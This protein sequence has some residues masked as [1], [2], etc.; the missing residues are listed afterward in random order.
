LLRGQAFAPVATP[1]FDRAPGVTHDLVWLSMSSATDGAIVRYTTNG[2]EPQRSSTPFTRPIL[3][4]TKTTI[5]AKAF[6]DGQPPSPT[7]SAVFAIDI[8]HRTAVSILQVVPRVYQSN[9]DGFLQACL[10][11]DQWPAVAAA[12]TMLGTTD[13][14]SDVSTT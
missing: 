9:P 4:R 6:K 2:A 14:L 12:T 3:L 11:L 13:T 1:T 7:A 5:K 10:H 8:R